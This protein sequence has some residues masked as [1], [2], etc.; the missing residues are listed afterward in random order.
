[1]PTKLKQHMNTLHS[2]G[3]SCRDNA[4]CDLRHRHFAGLYLN[5]RCLAIGYNRKSCGLPRSHGRKS[6]AERRSHYKQAREGRTHNTRRSGRHYK[7]S[8]RQK[9]PTAH[10]LPLSDSNKPKAKLCRNVQTVRQL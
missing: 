7:I 10:V 3:I 6:E 8:R 1:M 5:G 9:T 2:K 4:H